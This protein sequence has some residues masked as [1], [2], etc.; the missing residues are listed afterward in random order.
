[1]KTNF[2]FSVA[3]VV[4]R[5]L[6]NDEHRTGAPGWLDTSTENQFDPVAQWWSTRLLTEGMKVRLLPVSPW[7]IRIEELRRTRNADTLVRIQ[8]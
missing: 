1:M 7:S 3:Q 4:Q 2:L 5:R 6:I 8:N